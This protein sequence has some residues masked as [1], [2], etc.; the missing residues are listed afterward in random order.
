[1]NVIP[2]TVEN[3]KHAFGGY[4]IG[5]RRKEIGIIILATNN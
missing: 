5:H 3:M 1:M 2:W 4:S